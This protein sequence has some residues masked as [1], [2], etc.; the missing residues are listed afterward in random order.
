MDEDAGMRKG[1][2]LPLLPGAEQHGAQE[3]DA[4]RQQRAGRFFPVK[5]F[6]YIRRKNPNDRSSDNTQTID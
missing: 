4:V 3:D 1:G 2:A 6:S 5:F